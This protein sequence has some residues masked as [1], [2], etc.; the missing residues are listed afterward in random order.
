MPLQ[1]AVLGTARL[2]NFRL[3][4]LPA[5]LM[6]IRAT[7]VG[8][9]LSGVPI[10]GS[11]KVGSLRISDILNDAPNTCGFTFYGPTAPQP[12]QKLVVTLDADFP[13]VLFSG[14]LQTVAISYVGRPNTVAWDCAAIDDTA[15]AN[16]RRPFGVWNR[17][18]ATAVAVE[19][20][21]TYAPDLST[22]GIEAGLPLVDLILDGTEGM[23]AAFNQM[24]NLIGGYY[25]FEN[26][27]AFLFLELLD[28]PCDPIDAAHPF[29]NDPPITSSADVSQLRTRVYGKGHG[30]PTLTDVNAGE[31]LLP[32][33]DAVMFNPAGGRAI[34]ITQRLQYT[35]LDLGGAGGLA[36]PGVTPSTGPT[37]AAVIG[38][39][40][41]AGEYKYAVVFV[42][43]SGKTLPS[44]LAAVTTSAGGGTLPT[45]FTMIAPINQTDSPRVS[46]L[47]N[48][49]DAIEYAYSWSTSA[50][51]DLLHETN[52][53]LSN[54]VMS[55]A[56]YYG[57]PKG[58]YFAIPHAHPDATYIHLWRSINGAGF[59]KVGTTMR[60]QDFYQWTILPDSSVLTSETPP[61][62][63]AIL[64]AKAQVAISGV[65]VGPSGTISREIYRTSV[66][67]SS[68]RLQQTISNNTAT[69]G[70]QDA[71][72]DASLGAVA[73]GADT[74]ALTQ[75]VGQIN[76]GSTSILTAGAGFARAAGGWVAVPGSDAVRYTGVTGNTLTGIPASGPGA[77]VNTIRYGANLVGVPI[78][79]GV[80]GI[81]TA[82]PR[83]TP[84][85][86]WVQR[87]DP[88]GMGDQIVIDDINDRVLVDGVYEGPIIVDERRGLISLTALCDAVLAIFSKPIQTV[89]YP[90]RDIKTKSG[91]PVTVDLISPPITA[92]LVIQEV[93][94][95]EIDIAPGLYPRFEVTASSTRFSLDSLL[96]KLT[97]ALGV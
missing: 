96:R 60:A 68:L 73:P 43:V 55:Q 64:P 45:P 16:R 24:A 71:T 14:T 52:L 40:L 90:T 93:Q 57:G 15:L 41:G 81:V 2:N 91:K 39:G 76:A 66:N 63:N 77:L 95:T 51:D 33:N 29:L 72:P 83:G 30:E 17:V 20:I 18:S 75:A 92:D 35:G 49:G 36:G 32:I 23:S 4:Y 56:S 82:I 84:I 1:P 47:W 6:P 28:D 74:S 50:V 34:A 12:N 13:I 31:T 94:I 79:T 85:N 25:K 61:L 97:K 22:A 21:T 10:T 78:L 58:I 5:D 70:V 80:T 87:D 9:Y 37:V 86:L 44:P 11:V 65:P 54:T 42:T 59:R 48:P 89:R 62:A 27:V 67:G 88:S 53:S 46:G 38:T 26:G 8:I 69:T 3:N 19:L 7:R